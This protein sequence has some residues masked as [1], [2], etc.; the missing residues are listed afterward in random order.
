MQLLS[1]LTGL[2]SSFWCVSATLLL[3]DTEHSQALVYLWQNGLLLS[4]TLQS[5]HLMRTVGYGGL[6]WLLVR[7]LILIVPSDIFKLR[8]TMF[9]FK[10][11]IF[12]KLDFCAVY[13]FYRH[14]LTLYFSGL[15]QSFLEDSKRHCKHYNLESN[16]NIYV[17]CCESFKSE[18]NNF[19]YNKLKM[20]NWPKLMFTKVARLFSVILA[21]FYTR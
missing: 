4:N 1:C 9:T 14:Y 6:L 16:F 8:F 3:Q 12:S 20:N 17:N 19:F 18:F 11:N 2:V 21:G 13:I 5:L 10:F 15:S 7:I